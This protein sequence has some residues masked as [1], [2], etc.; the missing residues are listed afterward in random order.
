VGI[1][2]VSDNT[3]S[4]GLSCLGSYVN[5]RFLIIISF[6]NFNLLRSGNYEV[7]YKYLHT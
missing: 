2:D 5:W 6:R 4:R 3:M 7:R 1:L